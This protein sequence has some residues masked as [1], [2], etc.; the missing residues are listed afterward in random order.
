MKERYAVGSWSAQTADSVLAC[1]G[2]LHGTRYQVYSSAQLQERD[3]IMFD[4]R[5]TTCIKYN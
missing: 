4:F 2:T 5:A 3:I 1:K